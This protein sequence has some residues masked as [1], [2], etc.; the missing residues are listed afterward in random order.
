MRLRLPAAFQ[1]ISC[2]RGLPVSQSAI[3]GVFLT[4]RPIL[5]LHV[6]LAGKL[7]RA[8]EEDGKY[9]LSEK[10]YH[11]NRCNGD[12]CHDDRILTPESAISR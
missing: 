7:L 4:G 6:F 5:N 3:D 10:C 2:G 12:D 9:L 11:G 8:P 1:K